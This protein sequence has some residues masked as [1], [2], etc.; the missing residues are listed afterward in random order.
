MV[1]KEI[2]E[3]RVMDAPVDAVWRVITTI[4]DAASVLRGVERIEVVAGDDGPDGYAVG[5]RWKETRKILGRSGTEEMEVTDVEPGRSTR[6]TAESGG[7]VY[8]TT[9]ELQKIGPKTR[10]VVRF[11]GITPPDASVVTRGMVALFGGLGTLATGAGLRRD[12][13]DIEKAAAG[14][15]TEMAGGITPTNGEGTTP[16]SAAAAQ[17]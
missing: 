12:L 7:I 14:R 15:L 6:I 17:G 3:S 5:L 16:E 10:V 4:R 2:V 9:F 8:T 13:E 11:S 1:N